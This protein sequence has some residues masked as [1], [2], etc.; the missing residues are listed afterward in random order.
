MANDT[1]EMK[2]TETS[3]DKEEWAGTVIKEPLKANAV[4]LGLIGFGLTTSLLSLTYIGVFPANSMILGMAFAM[5]GLA[6]IIA[7]IME[8]KNGSTFSTVVFGAY[9]LFW[10]SLVALLM[11]PQTTFFNT[12]SG[13]A[14]AAPSGVALGIYLFFWGIFTAGI[15]PAAAKV[16][17]G[18]QGVIG[19]LA[20]LFF[21]LTIASITGNSVITIIAGIEGL[22]TGLIG[23]YTS[24]SGVVNEMYD[25]EVLPL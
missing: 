25:K 9:G 15:Y 12:G 16:N 19:G 24:I 7:S 17:R 11:I 10:L 6:E 1:N 4:P 22:I 13:S 21:L 3:I 14:L 5:G 8:F 20:I 23:I 2:T 18:V